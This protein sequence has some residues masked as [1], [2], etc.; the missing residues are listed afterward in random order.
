MIIGVIYN[1]VTQIVKNR[2]YK[3]IRVSPSTKWRPSENVANNDNG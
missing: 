1:V 2:S 3:R